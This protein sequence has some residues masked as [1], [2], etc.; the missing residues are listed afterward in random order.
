MMINIITIYPYGYHPFRECIIRGGR[1][2]GG[3]GVI[4]IIVKMMIMMYGPLV[5]HVCLT[6]V[7]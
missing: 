7:D 2:V 1:E 4:E 5:L 6:T 3:Q